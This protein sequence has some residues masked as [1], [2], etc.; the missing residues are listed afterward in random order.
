MR[1]VVSVFTSPEIKIL[2]ILL[3][4]SVD[5]SILIV[6]L[7]FLIAFLPAFKVIV[8]FLT[9]VLALNVVV[10]LAVIL[11]ATFLVVT[12]SFVGVVLGLGPGA[13]LGVGVGLVLLVVGHWIMI[14]MIYFNNPEAM[15]KLIA[16][17]QSGFAAT[18][19]IFFAT[20][21]LAISC[22]RFDDSAIWEELLNHRERIEK[23]E[24]ECNRLNTNVE[25][26]QGIL[27]ALQANDYVTAVTKIMEDGVEV[28]YSI[29]F[30]KGGTVTIYHGTNGEDSNSPKIG[31]KKAS[32]GQYYW[33]ADDEWLT[34]EDGEKIPAAYADGG[35]GRY[36]TPQ[37]RVDDGAWYVSLDS[38]NSWR[39]IDVLQDSYTIFTNVEIKSDC[40]VL[41]MSDG[42]QVIIP[43]SGLTKNITSEFVFTEYTSITASNGAVGST[44]RIM[45]ASGYVNVSDAS[46]ITLNFMKWTSGV[47][48]LSGYG[49]AFYDADK[50][51][52]SGVALQPCFTTREFGFRY[53]IKS[54]SPCS[55]SNKKSS[56]CTS[57]SSAVVA[58]TQC[59]VPFTLRFAFS[60][61]TRAWRR[62]R[63]FSKR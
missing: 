52:I 36:I 61:T 25:A 33:T 12:F 47:G 9:L 22:T 40:V 48:A 46:S 60:I 57:A 27:A 3:L 44:T 58:S 55:G 42:N 21:A 23:L 32:D 5:T 14:Y 15:L 31:I 63:V 59:S 26:L 38:G 1:T 30:S 8:Y 50:D 6:T 20:L 4:L 62:L 28:G 43:I 11:E 7:T 54:P 2:L 39:E 19:T 16:S 49:M 13:G 29:T 53:S 34:A 56:I 45:K 18:L 10:F 41:T 17:M 24:A 35:D 37:F 51:F